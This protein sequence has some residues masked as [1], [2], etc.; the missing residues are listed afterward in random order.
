[1]HCSRDR[2][3]SH[4]GPGGSIEYR[5]VCYVSLCLSRLSVDEAEAVC[6]VPSVLFNVFTA[7]S[8]L[9]PTGSHHRERG[10]RQHQPTV[11]APPA[12][13]HTPTTHPP[14][15]LTLTLCHLCLVEADD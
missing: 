13:T 5:Q 2:F 6:C 9:P 14:A 8:Q 10:G 7:A 15:S 3:H 12:S 1:M 11:S 4:A